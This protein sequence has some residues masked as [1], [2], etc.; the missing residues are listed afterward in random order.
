MRQSRDIDFDDKGIASIRKQ[1][2]GV[3][4]IKSLAL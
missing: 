4:D 1:I 3:E 2:I